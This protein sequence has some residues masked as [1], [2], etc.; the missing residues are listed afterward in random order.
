M[1]MLIILGTAIVTLLFYS[2]TTE[3][4]TTEQ[5]TT[6]QQ[7]DFSIHERYIPQ[8]EAIPIHLSSGDMVYLDPVDSTYFSGDMIFSK[9]QI[10]SL[11]TYGTRAAI[12]AD[13]TLYWPN[14]VIKYMIPTALFSPQE[15]QT[16]AAALNDIS[17]ATHLTFVHSASAP[18][19]T[20]IIFE[21]S[22][23]ANSYSP[24]GRESS[25]YNSI[26]LGNQGFEKRTVIHEVLHSLGFF[27]EHSRT[28]RDNY[29]N[30]LY[31]NIDPTF[32]YAFDTFID[33]GLSGYNLGP[34]DFESIML[35]GSYAFSINNQATITKKDGT[36]F[37]A[38]NT[39]LSDGDIAGL[40]YIYGPKPIL[41]TVEITAE[42]NGDFQS[43]DDLYIYSNYITFVDKNNNP[44][45][46]SYPRL[47][48]VT[49]S[50][51]ETDH[52]GETV[53][54]STTTQ[55]TIPAG[56]TTYQLGES[57]FQW[58]ADMGVDRYKYSSSYSLSY[59]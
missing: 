21:H 24:I 11:L 30:I 39:S 36:R 42:N 47:L 27:H 25:K 57:R 51:E 12:A 49:F 5:F 40:N 54:E 34:F 3:Q 56:T 59:Y 10:A 55:I 15:K 9:Q 19:I 33:K 43:I 17:N 52:L 37:S 16:I 41:N 31:N 46:L 26:K 22:S 20:K 29:I 44:I 2:C 1:K 7:T 4:F 38:N 8:G 23:D 48:W 32:S 53:R 35:Y 18:H 6:E 13:T 50:S 58:Q 14:K 45:S 28:D